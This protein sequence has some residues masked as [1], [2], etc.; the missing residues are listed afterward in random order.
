M[1]N[2]AVKFLF[3][4]LLIVLITNTELYAQ[5]AMCKATLEAGGGQKGTIG[6][7]LNT[8]ILYLMSVPYLAGVVLAYFWYKSAKAK[9]K[10]TFVQ[11]GL[12]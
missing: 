1:V 8:G 11:R 6:A 9:R 4:F 12:E 3:L 7:G 5:C 10:A 2:K